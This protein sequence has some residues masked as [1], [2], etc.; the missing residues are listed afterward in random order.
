MSDALLSRFGMTESAF[1]GGGVEADVF[2]IDKQSVLRIEKPGRDPKAAQ[3]R[4]DLLSKLTN[5]Q[6]SVPKVREFDVL[7]GVAFT[8][9]DR[10][11]GEPMSQTLKT[12]HGGARQD[13]ILDYLDVSLQVGDLMTVSSGA[14]FGELGTAVP[15]RRKRFHDFLRARAEASLAVKS[16]DVDL[17]SI[18][19]QVESP[20]N[21]ALVHLDYCPSNVLCEGNRITAVLDFGGTSILGADMF[22]PVVAKL[23]LT[24]AIT[25]QAT[26]SD[27]NLAS[28]WLTSHTPQD[29]QDA[30]TEWLAC[31]WSFCGTNEALPLYQW[32]LRTLGLR[33]G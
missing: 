15:I 26:P 25:P 8:V 22:N 24:P 5:A 3:H 17:D 11:E 14:E 16:L 32:C 20:E 1:L 19:S 12:L 2:L 6:F 18:L 27:L 28:E 23:F 13:L 7:E 4:V 21:A 9:E 29:V 10:L 30:V 31:Y 33:G